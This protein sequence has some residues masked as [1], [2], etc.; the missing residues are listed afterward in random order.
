MKVSV[1]IGQ[2][3]EHFDYDNELYKKVV[4][5]FCESYPKQ[6][7][8]L[9]EAF[10]KKDFKTFERMAHSI[11]GGVSNF[12]AYDVRDKAYELEVMGQ[13]ESFDD[14]AETMIDELDSLLEGLNKELDLIDISSL[15]A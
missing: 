10:E 15:A 11:K 2:L 1:D 9:K 3:C 14:Q 4:D 5:T 12:Y 6:I 13:D 8:E 7:S